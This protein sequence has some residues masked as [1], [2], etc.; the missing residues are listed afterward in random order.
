MSLPDVFRSLLTAPGPSGYETAAVAAWREAAEAFS[1][2]VRVDAVGTCTAR[3]P[4]TGDGPRVAVVGHID[5]IGVAIT[6][7]DDEGYLWFTEVGGWEPMVLV[8][9]R[10]AVMTRD[11]IVPGV[12]GRKPIHLLRK[13]EREKVPELRHLHIDIGARDRDEA[14]SMVRVGDVA[15]VAGEPVEL[16]NRRIASRSLDN[17]VGAFVALEVARLVSEAGG[18]PGDVIAVAS[19]QEEISFAGA[20]TTTYD[21]RPDVAI[22]VDVAQASDMPGVDEKETGRQPLGGGPIIMR[23]SVLHPGVFELLCAAAEAEG[24]PYAVHGTGRRTA[25]DA[26]GLHVVRSGVPTG[27]VEVP[28]RYMHSPVEMIQMDDVEATVRIIVAFAQRLEPGMSFER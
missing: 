5:E 25:N 27:S 7:I 12:V 8:A 10:M 21:V 15:V 28:L 11:G 22:V 19:A 24:I 3:I 9:Q 26:D 16:P 2:D 4:G 14:R 17:R 13:E 1:S 23:G 6:H 20:I 18:A